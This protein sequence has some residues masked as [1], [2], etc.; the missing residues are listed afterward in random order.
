MFN[1]FKKKLVRDKLK[2]VITV[3]DD[4]KITGPMVIREKETLQINMGNGL[5]IISFR[6]GVQDQQYI[7]ITATETVFSD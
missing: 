7:D 6:G 1:W 2:F 4:Y 5:V 3:M